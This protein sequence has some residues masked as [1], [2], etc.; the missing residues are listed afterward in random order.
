LR[1]LQVLYNRI[2]PRVS[3]R[4]TLPFLIIM[5]IVAGIGTFIVTRLVVGTIDERVNNQ[6]LEGSQ[7]VAEVITDI[8]DNQIAL[9]RLLTF[10]EG[11]DGAIVERDTDTL[12]R[13]LRG[14]VS[15]GRAD[16]MLIFDEGGQ[17]IFRIQ[18]SENAVMQLPEVEAWPI[19]QR[20]INGTVDTLGDKFIDIHRVDNREVIFTTAPV[21]DTQGQIV[22]GIAVGMTTLNFIRILSEQTLSTLILM[23]ETGAVIDSTIRSLTNTDGTRVQHL[24]AS[25]ANRILDEIARG[26]I[27]TNETTLDGLEYKLVYSQFDLRGE[28][29]G[30]TGVAIPTEFVADRI[31]TSRNT[32]AGL[33]VIVFLC[34]MMIGLVISRSIVRPLYRIVDTT[35]AIRDGDLTR[36][37]ELGAPDELGELSSSFDHMTDQLVA[38]NQ[39]INTLYLAQLEETARRE[40][41]LTSISD[42]VIVQDSTG[43]TILRNI[44][45]DELH[46][47]LLDDRVALQNFRQMLMNATHFNVP[48]TI[49]VV[50]RHFSVLATPVMMPTGSKL[51]DVVVFRD[52]TAIVEAQQ[53]KDKLI[54]QLSHEI[55]TPY[56]AAYGYAE[57]L[58]MM[59]YQDNMEQAR[60]FVPNIVT[61]LNTLGTM[62]NKVVEVSQI[63]AGQVELVPEEFDLIELIYEILNRHQAQLE[64]A[65]IELSLMAFKQELFV[66]ADRKLLDAAVESVLENAYQYTLPGGQ[67]GVR[68]RADDAYVWVEIKDT[69]VGIEPDEQEKVFQH[70]YRGRSADAGP[71]DTRGLGLGLYISEYYVHAHGG[72]IDLSSI[73]NKGTTVKITVPI[74]STELISG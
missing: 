22:G 62:L 19:V 12:D 26:L 59:I 42:I 32:F 48:E 60:T 8:E 6:L 14:L 50:G 51:G 47:Q 18:S 70:M 7:N 17:V 33:F 40:A 49:S 30:L 64:A 68:I 36:R 4:V 35:R 45:A 67:I 13:L 58:Q 65:D 41:V 43:R 15:N 61:H 16:E 71:T 74:Q 46:K 21:F 20:V 66:Q 3:T 1:L 73:E 24:N 69:G 31:G 54:L 37:V 53:L 23:D 11:V 52:I 55:R 25:E 28:T 57:L 27:P 56:A 2:Y 44:A 63:L 29:I 39:Q 9:L 34:V 72:T 10:T 5:L 38:R